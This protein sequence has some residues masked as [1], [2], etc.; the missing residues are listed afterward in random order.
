MDLLKPFRRKANPT[1][2]PI[3]AYVSPGRTLWSARDYKTLTEAGYKNVSAVFGCVQLIARGAAGIDWK[4]ERRAGKGKWE[5]VQDSPIA[6]L[7]WRPNEADGKARFN[8]SV[9]GYKLLS[10]NSFV[11]KTGLAGSPPRFLYALRPDRTKVVPGARASEPVAGY[12]YVVNGQETRLAVEDVLH[13]K[14]FNPTD[15][16]Y[17]LSRLEVAARAIDISNWAMEWNLKLLQNDMRP[18]GAVKV[19]GPLTKQQREQMQSDLRRYQGAENAGTVPIFEGGGEWVN[20][21]M[22]PKDMDWLN[23]EKFNLRRICAIFNV[24]SELLGDSEN[25]TYSN[26]QEARKALYLEAIL[27]EMDALRDE[28]NNWLVPAFG[29]EDRIDYD[30]DS[31]EAIQE[32]RAKKYAYLAQAEWLTVN[33]KRTATGYDEIPAGEVVLVPMGKIPL[34]LA[35]EEPEPATETQP[36]ETP[37]EDEEDEAA[38]E[39]A[40]RR[41]IQAKPRDTGK[42]LPAGR[43]F[44][45]KAERKRA[46]WDSYAARVKAKEKPLKGIVQGFLEDQAR[47]AADAVRKGN[48]TRPL[49]VEEE[50]RRY[51]KAALPWARQH[52][53]EAGEA[54]IRATKRALYAPG[55][56]AETFELRPDKA[57]EIYDMVV[58]SGTKLSRTTMEQ[59]LG[60][61]GQGETEGWTNEELTQE[62]WNQLKITAPWRSRL[63]ARTEMAKIENWGQ[64]EGYKQSE[65]TE[66]KGWLSA[67]APDTR[68]AHI[69]ADQTYRENTIGLDEYFEVDGELLEYPGDPAGSPGNVCNCLCTTFPEVVEIEGGDE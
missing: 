43:S 16:F 1:W 27:P 14:E 42:A 12:A 40:R 5:E 52:F 55:E 31:I 68:E 37:A 63:I 28:L 22:A 8:E 62:I 38:K 61:L 32:E 60:I 67:Y 54:G 35:I 24:A 20:L 19:A 2:G 51:A 58:N 25:K 65:F 3:L 56:K 53:A 46:L 41:R 57:R 47:R 21:S 69:Q 17:G 6:K 13:I 11:L 44:W 33:E 23:A 29:S 45:L 7:L 4:V 18:P 64:V 49:D 34:E 39:Q 30:R 36:E 15:D 9:V 26:I 48:R 66:R 59:V 50:A 10:G